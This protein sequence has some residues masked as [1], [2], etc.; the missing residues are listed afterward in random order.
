MFSFHFLPMSVLPGYAHAVAS[1]LVLSKSRK[2]NYIL[3]NWVTD[4]HE[5]QSGCWETKPASSLSVISSAPTFSLATYVNMSHT[6][7]LWRIQIYLYLNRKH[8]HNLSIIQFLWTFICLYS[9]GDYYALR[10]VCTAIVLSYVT[11]INAQL[12]NF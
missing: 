3:W 8:C 6:I 4:D 12:L 11:G 10:N 1:C 5:I 2:K 7:N 9:Y